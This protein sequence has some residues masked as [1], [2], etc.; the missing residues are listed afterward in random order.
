MDKERFDNL[1]KAMAR[2]VSRRT[3]AAGAVAGVASMLAISETEAFICRA[4]GVLCGKDAHCCSGLCDGASHR[5]VCADGLVACGGDCVDPQSDSGNCGACGVTCDDGVPCQGGHCG[6]PEH[7]VYCPVNESCVFNQCPGA[8]R[9]VFDPTTCD[10]ICD[11]SLYITMPGGGCGYA[12][13]AD[14]DCNNGGQNSNFCGT[15]EEGLRVCVEPS[16]FIE[17]P[18]CL[19]S[20]QCYHDF[21]HGINTVCVGGIC[22]GAI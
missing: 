1:T 21:N 4:P 2:R 9:T 18:I 22:R 15:T 11:P 17:N 3:L 6:C 5:C 12:C 14:S 19:T 20:Y 13:T 10:C 7:Y 16:T 8:A